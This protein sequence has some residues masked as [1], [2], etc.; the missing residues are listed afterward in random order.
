[1]NKVVSLVNEW[2]AFE[3]KHPEADIADFCRYYLINEKQQ[4]DSAMV[5]GAKPPN[6]ASLL[7]KTIGFITYSF[8]IYF[9]AAMTQTK[10][11]FPEAFYFLNTLR[12][13]GEVKKTD[14]ITH[15]MA[16]YTTGIDSIT[17]L[18]KAGLIS[19]R[20]HDTDKRAKLLKLTAEG[21]ELLFSCYPYIGKATEMIFGG[22]D[23]D[24]VK[25]CISILSRVEVKHTALSMAVR[26]MDFEEMY[27]KVMAAQ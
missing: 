9:K 7:M 21:E 1:M 16:E 14:L 10:L 23:K 6:D 25:L 8:D 13:V 15:T 4:D 24:T 5:K 18:I 20:Q 3:Q 19:E 27:T 12:F 2:D 17:K 26:H 11:P 22:L